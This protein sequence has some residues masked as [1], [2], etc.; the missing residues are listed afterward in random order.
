MQSQLDATA[1]NSTRAGG[2]IVSPA[3][4]LLFFANAGWLFALAPGFV[5]SDGSAHLQFWQLYFLTTPHRWITL[6]LVAS[7]PD[8]REGRTSIFVLIALL[9]LAVVV[10]VRFLTGAFVCLLFVDYIW[11]GWHFATQHAGVLRIYGRKAGAVRVGLERYAMRV[12]IFYVIVRTASWTTG[13]LDEV[14]KGRAFLQVFDW[15]MVSLPLLLMALELKDFTQLRLGKLCYLSSVCALYTG[16]LAALHFEQ[17]TLILALAVASAAFHAVEYLALITFYAW[18]RETVG[19]ECLFR[20]MARQWLAVL[21][22][23]VMLFGLLAFE[24]DRQWTE[25]WLGLNLW[26]AFLHYAYDGMIW[27]LRRSAT[28]QVLGADLPALVPAAL[29]EPALSVGS[30]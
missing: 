3:F 19:S 9:M 11:N 12:F 22:G 14:P 2:W 16:L 24:A 5:S 25:V 13:W 27:K 7:D 18:R 10:G 15:S 17:G 23:F 26:A 30:S 21:A 28:A 8:R 20:M 6:A 4:D 1:E 29:P